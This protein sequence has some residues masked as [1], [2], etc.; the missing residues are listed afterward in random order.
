MLTPKRYIA[1]DV[2]TSGLSPSRGGR[3]IEVGAVAF[4]DGRLTDEFGTLI[5]VDCS[6]HR[7]AQR[8][9][10]ISRVMLAGMPEPAGV[11]RDFLV[12][13]GGCP[14][15]AHNAAFDAAFLRNELS[16]LGMRMTHRF[17]CSLVLSRK[18]LPDLPNHRLATVAH[19]LL[20]PLPP[21]V[22]LHRALDDARLT[23]GIWMA[24][25]KKMSGC[26]RI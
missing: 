3:V 9:H 6:I 12:F 8:V 2:E 23:A 13:I 5:N 14:L 15:V 1:C 18:L 16:L 7:A 24:L 25:N 26:D 10:G 19:H 11:W 22:R 21:N 4:E 20:G 17:Y